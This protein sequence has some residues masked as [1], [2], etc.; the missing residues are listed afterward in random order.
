MVV[1][2]VM[3]KYIPIPSDLKKEFL[4]IIKERKG[5]H[6]GV[7]LESTIEAIEMWITH[8]ELLED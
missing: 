7:I 1:E 4:S 5:V 3:P 8:P 6:G 2:L